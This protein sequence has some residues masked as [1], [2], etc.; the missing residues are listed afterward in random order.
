MSSAALL[1]EVTLTAVS[2]TAAS[3]AC[4]AAPTSMSVVSSGAFLRFVAAQL[5]ASLSGGVLHMPTA[6]IATRPRIPRWLHRPLPLFGACRLILPWALPPSWRSLKYWRKCIPILVRYLRTHRKA[7]SLTKYSTPATEAAVAQTIQDLWEDQHERGAQ[8]ITAMLRDLKGFYLKLGQI[9]GT[10]ADLLPEV[11]TK[12]LSQLFDSMPAASDRHVQQTI[13][14][15][16]GAPLTKLFPSFDREPLAS[17][18]VAQVHFAHTAGGHAVAVKIQ[19]HGAR[20]MM[21]S[22]LLQLRLLTGL[23]CMLRVDLGF[24]V[25][26]IIREYCVQVPHEFDFHREAWAAE[27][28][29]RSMAAEASTDRDLRDVVIPTPLRHL[30]ARRVL[31]ADFLRGVP[32]ARAAALPGRDRRRLAL[33]LLRAFGHMIL[34]DGV[35]H[36][37]PHPGNLLA[38]A[39]TGSRVQIGL[40]DFGQVKELPG[41]AQALYAALVVAMAG[42]DEPQIR[43]CMRAAGVVVQN[44]SPRFEAIA[45]MIMFD[46][47]MDFPEARMAP[48]DAAAHEFRAANVKNL[49]TELFMI[50]RVMT[51]LRGVLA[52]L[53]VELA[54]ST[55]WLPLAQQ[56]LKRNAAATASAP[57]T[58]LVPVAANLPRIPAQRL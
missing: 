17:A 23:L 3:V 36:S 41:H 48:T 53:R 33:L 56:A 29:A 39:S 19:H 37:D 57:S 46:T 55:L 34:C 21:L 1:R 25:H 27:H 15:E 24:D 52:Q 5:V 9:L 42:G 50:M 14:R 45:G 6:V 38:L 49:P 13:R 44:C 8:D 4:I 26:S 28:I 35:F 43:A 18:T 2:G 51:I 10:K 31:T 32:L 7:R 47:R 22:D 12:A 20:R 30:S 11:Y 16:L 54:A 58:P 40:L